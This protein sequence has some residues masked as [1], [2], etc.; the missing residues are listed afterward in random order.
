MLQWYIRFVELRLFVVRHLV[1]RYKAVACPHAVDKHS[2]VLSWSLKTEV[3]CYVFRYAVVLNIVAVADIETTIGVLVVDITRSR[4]VGPYL[5]VIVLAVPT[6]VLNAKSRVGYVKNLKLM[7]LVAS[8]ED[9]VAVVLPTQSAAGL[10]LWC[11]V[12]ACSAPASVLH[13]DS[14]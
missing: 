11:S 10:V 8:V 1:S 2:A 5:C 6:Y 14:I 7:K 4:K 9:I 12:D 3:N 13:H